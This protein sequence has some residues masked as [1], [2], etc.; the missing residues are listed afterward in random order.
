[1][2]KTAAKIIN[3]TEK[4]AKDSK[5]LA[6]NIEK[7]AKDSKILVSDIEKKKKDRGNVLR[8]SSNSHFNN[9]L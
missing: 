8:K 7:Q 6:S 9:V 1:M 2:A 5:I 4:Q 3:L